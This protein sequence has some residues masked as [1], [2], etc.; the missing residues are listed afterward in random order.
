MSQDDRATHSL[1][2][3]E[4][5][6]LDGVSWRPGGSFAQRNDMI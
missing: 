5:F 6:G 3:H 1:A 4:D 2:R